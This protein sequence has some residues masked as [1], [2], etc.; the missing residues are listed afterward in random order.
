MN[1]GFSIVK[2]VC[3]TARSGCRRDI[4]ILRQDEQ[5]ISC[6]CDNPSMNVGEVDAGLADLWLTDYCIY[7]IATL[8]V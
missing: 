3:W 6:M 8:C 1:S 7:S 4:S 5:V 2:C